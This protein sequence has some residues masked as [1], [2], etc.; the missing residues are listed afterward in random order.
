MKSIQFQLCRGTRS[1]ESQNEVQQKSRYRSQSTCIYRTY[2]WCA[3]GGGD[4]D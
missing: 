4:V 2:R 1:D 3:K